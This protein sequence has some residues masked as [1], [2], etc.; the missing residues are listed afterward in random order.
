[1]AFDGVDDYIDCG[2][3]V[4]LDIAGEITAQAWVRLDSKD[5]DSRLVY[6]YDSSNGWILW[7]DVDDDCWEFAA[8]SGSDVAFGKFS[9]VSPVVDTWYHVVG[10]YDGSEISIMVN[11]VIGNVQESLDS[12]GVASSNLFI[13]KEYVPGSFMDGSID[14]VC[15]SNHARSWEW[16]NTSFLNQRYPSNFCS[17]GVEEIGQIPDEPVIESFSPLDNAGN[18]A[19][20]PLLFVSLVDWQG[21]NMDVYFRSNVSGSWQTLSSNISVGN[22]SYSCSNTGLMSDYNTMYWWSVNA[23]DYGSG[24]WSNITLS[25]ST[26]LEPGV[27]WN[28]SW[29]YRKGIMIDH[30]LVA[31]NLS[32]FPVLIHLFDG[33]LVVHAQDDGDDL[34]FTDEGGVQLA[35]E[36]EFYNHSSGELVVWVNVSE[37]SDMVD[38]LL[39]MYYGNPF[40]ENEHSID[41]VWDYDY[42]MVHH[43]LETSGV[44]SDSSMYDNNGSCS[45][46]VNQDSVGMVDGADSFDGSTGYIDCG[47]DG[48]LDVGNLLTLEAW[49]KPSDLSGRHGIFSTRVHNVDG[50]FQVEVGTGY[51]GYHRV[52]VATQGIWNLETFNDAVSLDQWQHLV[53][54]KNGT[55]AGSQRIY[56]NGVLQSLFVDDPQLFID[57]SD[58]KELGRGTNGS[59]YFAGGLDELRVSRVPRD[60]SWINTSYL[61]QVNPQ[62]FYD[63]GVEETVSGDV[64]APEITDMNVVCSDPMDTVIGWENISCIVIDNVDV[65][66]V[67]VNITYPDTHMDNIS[68][69][70]IGDV[71]YY[72]ATF[73]DVGSYSYFVWAND[74]SGNVNVSGVGGFVLPPNWDVFVDGVCNGLDVTF[75]SLNWLNSGDAGWIRADINNDGWVNG[76]DITFVS[77]HWMDTWS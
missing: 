30:T 66:E 22:G 14:E 45:V 56:I 2:N 77:L 63:V 70:R 53:F 55:T 6:R 54:V 35:H 11:G 65:D 20:S 29:M 60:Y 15:V 69:T 36:I 43:L 61:N 74:S 57:N 44:H 9:Q 67:W 3:D 12:M 38:T 37:L 5:S 10:V 46:G 40:A 8:R 25:F 72:N 4:S 7:Y 49:V 16:I 50:S 32:G 21:D 47:N 28:S 51:G 17:F 18:V 75:I 39:Y 58:V 48:S 13:G 23:T 52:A 73:S 62:V 26:M 76:L 31:G 19:L 68:M 24:N 27:W 71:F 42:V 33:D 34:V 41:E 64:V 59:Q 1:M